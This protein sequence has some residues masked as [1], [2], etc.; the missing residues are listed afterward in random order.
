MTIKNNLRLTIRSW[1]AVQFYEMFVLKDQLDRSS[2]QEGTASPKGTI[3][4]EGIFH[5]KV[6]KLDR[7]ILFQ[8]PVHVP[9]LTVY[10]GQSRSI[11]QHSR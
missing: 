9:Q 4:V 11:Y 5:V 7:A 3:Y 10:R 1:K 6:Q 8:R 2:E